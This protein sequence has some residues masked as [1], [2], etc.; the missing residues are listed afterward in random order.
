MRPS[1]P[2]PRAW[3]G[4]QPTPWPFAIA[5]TPLPSRSS[6]PSVSSGHGRSRRCRQ[7][8]SRGREA[9]EE[10]LRV[11]DPA[12]DPALGLDHL[13]GDSLELGEV[14]ADAVRQDERV[15][16]AVVLLADARGDADLGRHAADDQLLD[17]LH[18]ENGIEA[19]GVERALAGLVDDRLPVDGEDLLDDAVAQ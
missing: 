9:P 18:L 3:A 12:E 1:R 10:A 2:A 15:V 5:S 16:A 17:G 8:A 11:A 13:Q 4:S 14:G 19:R 6:L 7:P